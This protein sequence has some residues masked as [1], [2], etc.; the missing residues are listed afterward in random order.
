MS[1]LLPVG[2]E[3]HCKY[4]GYEFDG[5]IARQPGPRFKNQYLIEVTRGTG[6]IMEGSLHDGGLSGDD[7][8]CW[9]VQMKNVKPLFPEYKYNPDQTGDTEEDI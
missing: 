7:G 8:D 2:T 9:F 3:V 1:D 6:H 5:K 4:D